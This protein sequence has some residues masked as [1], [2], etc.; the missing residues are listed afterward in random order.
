MNAPPTPNASQAF[1]LSLLRLK[2]FLVNMVWYITGT[3]LIR[4]SSSSNIFWYIIAYIYICTY[5]S[6]FFYGIELE[7]L[8]VF[9]TNG[10]FQWPNNSSD[11]RCDASIAAQKPSGRPEK[12]TSEATVGDGYGRWRSCFLELSV[13]RLIII[14]LTAFCSSLRLTIE[15]ICNLDLLRERLWS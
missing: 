12:L 11:L 15:Y 8:T 14:I 10:P 5:F 13:S 1:F 9:K 4:V 7:K 3:Y 2:C 6:V